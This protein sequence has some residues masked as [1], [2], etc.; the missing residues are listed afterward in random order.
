MASEIVMKFYLNNINL[1][2]KY[3]NKKHCLD[4]FGIITLKNNPIAINDV[5]D[6]IVMKRK[7]QVQKY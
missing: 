1:N 2:W 6:A 4:V 7:K 3:Y 5:S